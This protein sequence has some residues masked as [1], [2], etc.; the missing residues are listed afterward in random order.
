MFS[1]I[2]FV[3]ARRT[4]RRRVLTFFF[5]RENDNDIGVAK[6][7]RIETSANTKRYSILLYTVPRRDGNYIID[8]MSYMNN[9]ET[10]RVHPRSI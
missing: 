5:F 1:E 6:P 9:D 7:D 10:E 8:I 3:D 4:S 2:D